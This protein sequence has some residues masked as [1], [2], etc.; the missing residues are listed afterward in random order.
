MWA[1]CRLPESKVAVHGNDK[2][3]A[4][5]LNKLTFRYI[6]NKALG[7]F[8]SL[9]LPSHLIIGTHSLEYLRLLYILIN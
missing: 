8:Y 1:L 5:N 7:S 9:R 3:R 2:C 6:I 4:W